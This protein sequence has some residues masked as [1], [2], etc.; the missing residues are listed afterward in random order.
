LVAGALDHFGM[1]SI[2]DEQTANKY[3]DLPND[4]EAKRNYV[5]RTVRSFI[6]KL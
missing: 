3:E 5:Q 6:D 4:E 1:T 2:N